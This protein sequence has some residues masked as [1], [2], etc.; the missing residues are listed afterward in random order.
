[1]IFQCQNCGY[2]SK[3]WLGKCPQCNEWNTFLEEKSNVQK[4]SSSKKSNAY[5]LSEIN[6]EFEKKISTGFQEFDRVLGGGIVNGQVI[7][8]G[9]NPGIGKSTL[10]T[11]VLNNIST[12]DKKGIYLSAEESATQVKIRTKRLGIDNPNIF[13]LPENNITSALP[14][15]EKISPRF[16]VID[17]I[18]TVYS[19]FSGSIPGSISQIKECAS[20][21]IEFVKS[22]GTILFFIGHVTKEGAIAGPKILEHMV[23]T[24]L[25]FE[26][27]TSTDFRIIRALKNRFGRVNEI[28][29]FEMTVNGLKEVND[30]TNIFI[31]NRGKGAVGSVIFPLVEGSRVFL[32]EVQSLVSSTNYPMPRRN[33][34]GV[35]LNRINLLITVVEKILGLHLYNHDIFVNIPGGIKINDPACDLAVVVAIV[36]SFLN[37]PL[38]IF[39]TCFG[40]IGLNGEIRKAS[41]SKSRIK[42]AAR[43]GFNKVITPILPKGEKSFDKIQT[44]QLDSI[45]NLPDI[46]S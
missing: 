20:R 1:M 36:S 18:Q 19:E 37:K 26:S 2:V 13:I 29:I 6:I 10:L 28:A 41:Y 34:Q 9:G 15:I 4:H 25:Y 46:I 24:V 42:E 22:N 8:I 38:D 3:K 7:L 43:L 39:L 32:V 33:S 45:R 31:A 35:D 30:P 12:N 5:L 11:Q 14:L 40:E 21:L 44:I 17:S 27:E 23:D 16:I